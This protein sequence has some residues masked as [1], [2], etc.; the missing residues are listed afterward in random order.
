MLKILKCF[1]AKMLKILKCYL[2]R[3]RKRNMFAV[4]SHVEFAVA[5]KGEP[6]RGGGY[7]NMLFLNA[8]KPIEHIYI[9]GFARVAVAADY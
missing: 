2:S 6:I 8:G 7:Q 1:S 4:K 3:Y 9:I 5:A